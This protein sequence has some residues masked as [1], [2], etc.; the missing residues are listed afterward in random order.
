MGPLKHEVSDLEDPSSDFPLMVPT[1]SLLVASGADNC[2]LMS[3][4]EQVNRILLS[5]CGSVLVEGLYSWGAMV[6]VGGQHCFS[7]VGK[8]EGCEPCGS[9]WGRS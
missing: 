7:S 2:R 3:L 6:E 1:K 4:L 5:L 9:V 8:E